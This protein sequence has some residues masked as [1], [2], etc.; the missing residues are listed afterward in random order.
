MELFASRVAKPSSWLREY[1]TLIF[2]YAS[3]RTFS[4]IKLSILLFTTSMDASRHPRGTHWRLLNGE[5]ASA[6]TPSLQSLCLFLLPPSAES[7]GKFLFDGRHVV[8]T[9]SPIGH[10]TVAAWSQHGRRAVTARSPRG[11]NTVAA[12]S[13]HGCCVVT[14][15]LPCSHNTV[16]AQSH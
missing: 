9:W 13:Q 4:F 3:S 12:W 6:V 16:T 10:N 5:H 11:H 8:T 15:W 1:R 14:A 2:S 7:C